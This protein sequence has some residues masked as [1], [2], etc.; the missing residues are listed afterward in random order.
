VRASSGEVGLTDASFY[1]VV[2]DLVG[3]ILG[4]RCLYD[5]DVLSTDRLLDLAP[6]LA[7]LELGKSAVALRDTEDVAN[8]VD[9][10][11][12]GVAPENN[13]IADHFCSVALAM[14]GG[15]QELTATTAML[16]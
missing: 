8:I 10:L 9:E 4:A 11:R 6:A 13:E 16:C 1:E 5:V 14:L 3:R 12:V 7:D 15:T 2:V